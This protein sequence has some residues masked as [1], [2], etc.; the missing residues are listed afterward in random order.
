[1][2]THYCTRRGI[3]N[4]YLYREENEDEKKKEDIIPHI[5]RVAY[6]RAPP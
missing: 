6:A 2:Q 1:M 3:E 5:R 4:A